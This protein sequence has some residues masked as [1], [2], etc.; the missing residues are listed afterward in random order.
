[1]HSSELATLSIALQKPHRAVQPAGQKNQG[2]APAGSC[3]VAEM[4]VV[5]CMMLTPTIKRGEPS[6]WPVCTNLKPR[7]LD[8]RE[9]DVG[10]SLGRAP[11]TPMIRGCR[12]GAGT[13]VAEKIVPHA[14]I[15]SHYR[16]A[17]RM[18]L[19]FA[20]FISPS[21]VYSRNETLPSNYAKGNFDPGPW[22]GPSPARNNDTSLDAGIAKPAWQDSQGSPPQSH[23]RT[24][25]LGAVPGL[26]NPVLRRVVRRTLTPGHGVQRL[27]GPGF[28]DCSLFGILLTGTSLLPALSLCKLKGGSR[29]LVLQCH[30]I[31]SPALLLRLFP[32][33]F[34]PD[35]PDDV[36]CEDTK[37]Q[38]HTLRCPS[39]ALVESHG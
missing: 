2:S 8:L 20:L 4:Y 32:D 34:R 33:L 6:A 7:A 11:W 24:L 27:S 26:S 25:L 29:L 21:R 36:G 12:P 28:Y 14:G 37:L 10:W 23:S 16:L 3:V 22:S 30:V 5:F 13:D 31:K 9:F 19:A 38:Y 1:M 35:E 17:S 15:P 39:L 18:K